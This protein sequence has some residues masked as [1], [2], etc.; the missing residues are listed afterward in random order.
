[1]TGTTLDNTFGRYLLFLGDT[2]EPGYAKT[3]FGLRDWARERCVG[4]LA[5][6]AAT[7]TTGLPALTPRQAQAQGATALVIGVA[8]PGGL[9]PPAWVPALL[10]AL[11]AGLDLVSGMHVK[12]A[13]IDALR[14][15]AARLDRRLIDIR[16]PPA[17]IP[18]A[19]GRRRTGWRVLTVGT[20]CALGKKYTALALTRALSGRGIDA[21]FRASGQTGI[22]IAGGGMP[23]DAVVADFV[24][25]AAELL[26][27]A[28]AADHVDVIEG[29]G[30]LFHPAYAGVSLGLLHGSQPDRFIVCH[31]P[32]R[33]HILG[34]P[35]TPLPSVEAVIALTVALGRITNPAIACAG[36]ALNTSALD[37]VAAQAEIDA[38]SAR[39][40]LP[41]ADPLRG[42]ASFERL[43][44]HCIIPDTEQP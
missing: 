20:D 6:P 34:L 37:A 8:A 1:M 5:L 43:V 44:D 2:V 22:L 25:G 36:V 32:G 38:L 21:S 40:G 18:V 26:S 24:A 39:L 10:A 7:V 3:A 13:Q 17:D 23:I 41:V 14:E 31:D 12:L 11:E 15:A 19:N 30:S 35:E 4:E 33:T 27:P 28:S 42:G 16:T 29:Q 9:I